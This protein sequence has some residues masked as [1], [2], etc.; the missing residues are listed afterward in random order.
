MSRRSLTKI[1]CTMGPASAQP[2]VLEKLMEAGMD[3]VRLNFSHG[4]HEDHKATFQMVR[5]AA[6]R[7]HREICII[8][9]LQGPKIRCNK[10]QNGAMPLVAG[11]SVFVRFSKDAI[12]VPG[13]IFTNF[14]PIVQRCKVGERLLIDDG[15]MEIVVEELVPEGLRCRIVT[16]GTIKDKKGINLP[17]TDLGPLPALTEKDKDDARFVLRELDVDYFALSFVRRAED[18]LDL[19]HIVV[20]EFHKNVRLC[21]KI[22]KPQAITNLKSILAVVDSIMVARGDLGVEVGNSQVPGLQKLIIRKC[23]KRGIPVITATQMLESMTNNP[24]PTRAEASDVACAVFDG[25]DA[26][27]LSGETAV[28]KYPVETVA[29]MKQIIVDAEAQPMSAYTIAFSKVANIVEKHRKSAE[30]QLLIDSSG[31]TV[32]AAL[33]RVA[34]LLAEETGSK[35][36]A[37][38]SDTGNAAIR[39]TTTR[40]MLPL[41]TFTPNVGTVRRLGMVRGAWGIML[42]TMPSGDEAF[43]IMEQALVKM[44]AVQTGDSVVYTVGLPTL[45][46]ATTNTLHIHRV[47]DA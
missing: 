23:L 1:V 18:V 10:V 33:G 36:L 42:P 34:H 47:G 24:R 40:P 17:N 39:I 22:E 5:D 6:A 44:G 2:A 29:M 15:L 7:L 43:R 19:R 27:M 13:T 14:E 12:C 8:A 31:T 41:F 38:I 30:P 16:G 25:T 32:G 3:C 21:A 26:V 11:E 45:A 20:D 35:A 28:G 9:D 4:S 46:H 37:C